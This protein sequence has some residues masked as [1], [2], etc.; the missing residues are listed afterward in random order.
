VW[1]LGRLALKA[2]LKHRAPVRSF[3]WDPSPLARGGGSRLAVSTAD[4]ALFLWSPT[5]A[6]AGPCPLSLAKLRWRSDGR[7]LLIQERDRACTCDLGP[8]AS[9]NGPPTAELE[10]AASVRPPA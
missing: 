3:A 8:P 6:L 5:K 2:L 7:S 9:L 1:D 4:P 10:T